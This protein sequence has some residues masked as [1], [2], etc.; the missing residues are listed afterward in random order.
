MAVYRDS[1]RSVTGEILCSDGTKQVLITIV[2][3]F[4]NF[5][6][7]TPVKYTVALKG[8]IFFFYPNLWNYFKNN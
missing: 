8:G 6:M 1:I 4:S 3:F 7:D 2:Y 5:S